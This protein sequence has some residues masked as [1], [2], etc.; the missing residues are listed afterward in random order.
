MFTDAGTWMTVMESAGELSL[1]VFSSPPPD[2]V[3]LFCTLAGDVVGMFTVSESAGKSLPPEIWAVLVQVMT[4]AAEPQ[5]QSAVLL[6]L[7]RVQ[8]VGKV[9]T[10]VVVPVVTLLG[11]ILCA[12]SEIA[13][14]EPCVN[15]PV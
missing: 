3:A 6:L 13:P 8:P 10:I 11:A 2:M 5:V 7:A 12:C 15:V 9:S 1:A 4:F 14:V